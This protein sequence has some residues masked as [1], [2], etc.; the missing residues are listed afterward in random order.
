M[1][2]Q[3]LEEIPSYQISRKSIQRFISCYIWTDR[4]GDIFVSL[5]TN[6]PKI[7]GRDEE[8]YKSTLRRKFIKLWAHNV[9]KESAVKSPDRLLK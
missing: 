1:C 6:A 9:H 4:Y 2:H 7:I 5:D 8:P 3:V